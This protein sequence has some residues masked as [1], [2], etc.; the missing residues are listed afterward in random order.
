M[1]RPAL[2]AGLLVLSLAGCAAQD[3][4]SAAARDILLGDDAAATTLATLGP[5]RTAW[6]SRTIGYRFDDS[7]YYQIYTY[8]SQYW[9][10]ENEGSTWT[11]GESRR[12]GVFL[13]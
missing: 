7:T 11:V 4:R 3:R 10:T 13:R 6:P 2:T 1:L 5:L 9:F 8:D 12:A